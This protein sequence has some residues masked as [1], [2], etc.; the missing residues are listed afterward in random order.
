MPIARIETYHGEP[1][2][3][4]NGVPYPPMAMTARIEQPEYIRALGESGLKVFF[5]MANTNWLRPGSETEP[6]GFEALSQSA[7]DLLR[8]VPDAYIII[9]VGLHPPVDWF[10]SHPDSIM[11]YNDGSTREVILKS[12]VHED[13]IPGMYSFSSDDWRTDAANALDGF[14]DAVDAS[15]FADRVIGYFLA[16]GGTSEWYPINPITDYEHDLYADFSPAFLREFSRILKEKY[17]TEEVLRKAWNSP[18]ATFENPPIPNIDE[19]R[20]VTVEE[21][22]FDAMLHEEDADRIIGKKIERNPTSEYNLGVFLNAN[23][24]S[25]VADF[26]YAWHRAT[27]RGIIYFAERLKRRDADKLVGAF[28]GSYGCTDFFNA[29][30]AGATLSI[31]DSGVV[32]F[33]A[34]PGVYNNREPGGYV[35]QREMQDSFRLRNQMFVVEEDS[36][37]HLE[38]DFYRDAMG[39]Y[40]IQDTI[41]TLKRDFARNICEDIYAWWFDQHKHSG[42]YR[43]EEIY[44]LFRR[45]QEISELAYS[46]DRAKKNEIALIYD[47]ESLFYVSTATNQLMLD[48]YRTSDLNRIGA[49]VDYYFHDDLKRS[50]MPDYKLYVMVNLFALTDAERD[51][52]HRKAAKNGATVLWLYAPGF[53]NPD[54]EVKMDNVYIE[55]LTGMKIGRIDDTVPPRFKLAC[56]HPA[57]RMGDP[58][59][60]YGTIDR[61]V[62]SNV[63]LAPVI[64][65]AYANPL[66]YVDDPEAEVLGRYCLNQKTAYALKRY[67]GFTSVYCAA[68]IL[69]AELIAS[70][71]AHAGCHLFSH[72][73]DL[74]YA[75]ENFVCIHAKES[76]EK[77]LYFKRPCSPFEVYEQRYYGHNLTR[78][79]LPMRLGET[80]MFCIGITASLTE[81]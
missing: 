75:N 40:D 55:Q 52:I 51:E 38:T 25:A 23:H 15:V 32:D 49:P 46:L 76:G 60:R 47:Q 36:R 53:I 4:I 48:Y 6:S 5:L 31:M 1:A 65:P 8:E 68:Q 7:A 27:A 77:M 10:F 34:A 11:R 33:L 69:R 63:W 42:R 79:T 73:D 56:E 44:R 45:Q 2:I 71:A 67:K 80:K 58:Y 16:A 72:T 62:H 12:E 43:H 78:L 17:Q 37:T 22:I 24:H 50:D 28:Y 66:F 41:D 35:A 9:R 81:R 74:I 14:C 39:L 59:R 3:L 21:K 19:R 57:T 18:D 70:L 64:P 54:R 29:S 26:F 61:D 20:Y 30:T 13:V